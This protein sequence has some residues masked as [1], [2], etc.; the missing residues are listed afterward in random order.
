MLMFSSCEIV[1]FEY[2][3][4]EVF[5]TDPVFIVRMGVTGV[6]C[7]HSLHGHNSL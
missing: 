6:G 3:G 2:I 1:R 5:T 4:N 7:D